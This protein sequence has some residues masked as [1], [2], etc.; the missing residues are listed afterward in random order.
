MSG[1]WS[2]GAAN[3]HWG[4]PGSR[5]RNVPGDGERGPRLF[6]ALA[7]A[8][9]WCDNCGRLHPLAEH[10]DCRAAHPFQSAWRGSA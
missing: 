1:Q 7:A 3:R 6:T 10:R 8:R 2:G 9:F 5:A 4:R